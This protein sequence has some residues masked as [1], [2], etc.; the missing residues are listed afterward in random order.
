MFQKVQDHKFIKSFFTDTLF[1]IGDINEI[2][3]FDE[4]PL[5]SNAM[6]LNWI[7]SYVFDSNKS[8]NQSSIWF[9]G[10]EHRYIS[11]DTSFVNSSERVIKFK[12]NDSSSNNFDIDTSLKRLL[13]SE[14]TGPVR[15]RWSWAFRLCLGDRRLSRSRVKFLSKP[16]E[17]PARSSRKEPPY[18]RD[19]PRDSWRICKTYRHEQC[20]FFSRIVRSRY[21]NLRESPAAASSLNGIEVERNDDRPRAPTYKTSC[22]PDFLCASPRGA[23]RPS[24]PVVEMTILLTLTVYVLQRYL[25]VEFWNLSFLQF[26]RVVARTFYCAINVQFV[27]RLINYESNFTDKYETY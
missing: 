5:K 15:R 9:L 3:S 19:H 24:L 8:N 22:A 2:L 6:L 23:S 27:T 14:T 16:K 1:Y 26:S 7:V 11:F 12:V 21:S 20:P 17:S 4:R 25:Y 18:H 13:D 10:D